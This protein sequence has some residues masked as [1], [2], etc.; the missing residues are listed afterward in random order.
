MNNSKKTDNSRRIAWSIAIPA[1]VI[2]LAFSGLIFAFKDQ[3][4]QIM[5]DCFNIVM[6]GWG[7]LWLVFCLVCFFFAIWL[8][9]GKFGNMRFGDEKPDTSTFSFFC[10]LFVFGS[11]ASLV[12]WV[13]VEWYMYLAGPPFGAEPYSVEALKWASTYGSFHW[14]IIPFSSYAVISIAYAFF[15]YV[16]KQNTSRVSACC[17]P[18]IGRRNADGIIGKVIDCFFLIGIILSN[19]GYS[20]GVS[21]PIVGTFAA[22]VFGIEHTLAL[23][24]G[25]IVLITIACAIAMYTGLNKG[26]T[27]MNDIRVTFFFGLAIFVVLVGPTSFIVNNTIESIGWQAQHMF[28]MALY[29]GAAD[30]SGWPQSWT[31]FF[32]IMFIAPI[33]TCGLYYGKLCKGR[34]VRECVVC[35]VIASAIGCAIFFWTLGNYSI[36]TYLG[37]PQT[38]IAMYNNSPYD[39]ITYVVDTLPGAKIIMV[40]LLAYA[41]LSTW[42]YIQ[43]AIYGNAMAAQPNLPDNEEPSKI[44]R[45]VWCVVTGIM[46]IALLYIGGIQTVKNAMV[47][48]GVPMFIIAMLIIIGNYKDMFKIWGK[49]VPVSQVNE[50]YFAGKKAKSSD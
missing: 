45:I 9:F 16:R 6:G 26:M 18:L 41:F 33:V 50:E 38:F 22:K 7:W 17:G 19:A 8:A 37:D 42:T 43:S 25:I 14:G 39:A 27:I 21:V 35:I 3:M 20:L 5:T 10:N 32:N 47:P 11:S 31:M 48:A 29:T 49:G 4:N 46:T 36:A 23:D 1:I 24:T 40:I 15:I 2:I 30:G 28:Q 44:G 13:F 34:T 12:Y